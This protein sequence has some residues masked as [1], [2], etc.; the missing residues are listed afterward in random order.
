MRKDRA[1]KAN[2]IRYR[3]IATLLQADGPLALDPLARESGVARAKLK[4]VLQKLVGEGAVVEGELVAGKP[5][6]Q[7]C[8]AERWARKVGREAVDSLQRIRAVV[9]PAEREGKRHL[10]IDSK[11]MLD[12]SRF[13]TEEYAPPKD[14]RILVFFQCSVRRPFSTSPSHGSMRRAVYAATGFWPRKEFDQCPVHVVVLASTLG[15]VPYELEDVFPANVGG[16]GVKHFSDEHYAHVKP[17]LA[18]RMAAY[19]TAHRKSYDHITTFTDGRYGEVMALA[20]EIA[21]VDFPIYPVKGGPRVL[22][23]DGSKPRTYWQKFWIQLALQIID[24]L[25]PDQQAAAR[26]RLKQLK[27]EYR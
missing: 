21:G 8:W 4:P 12:F 20:S 18:E 3:L 1:V 19:I 9:A 17:I 22:D 13:V 11:A 27:V 23:L 14:K 2:E 5:S 25:D 24:W 10:P 16:G 6:P 15:P 26:R 7:Y